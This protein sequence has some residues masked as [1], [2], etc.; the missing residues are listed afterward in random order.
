MKTEA[1]KNAQN[2][3]RRE[4]VMRVPLDLYPTDQDIIDHLQAVNNRQRYIKELIREDI[5]KK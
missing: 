5:K 4:K 1:L 3:Y 2:K